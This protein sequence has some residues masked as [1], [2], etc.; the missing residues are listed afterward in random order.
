[1]ELVFSEIASSVDGEDRQHGRDRVGIKFVGSMIDVIL[2]V[3][4][5]L[6]GDS[7][8][9]LHNT[10]ITSTRMKVSSQ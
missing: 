2:K 5:A 7:R 3:D 6:E 4:V 1:M 10:V 9:R 8:I